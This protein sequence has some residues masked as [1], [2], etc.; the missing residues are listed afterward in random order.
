MARQ[1]SIDR[2]VRPARK[3]QAGYP[4]SGIVVID[5]DGSREYC[6]VRFKEEVLAAVGRVLPEGIS[7]YT[8]AFLRLV[9][10]PRNEWALQVSYIQEPSYLPL[11]YYDKIPNWVGKRVEL[12]NVLRDNATSP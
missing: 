12:C 10:S 1:V 9:K 3:P 5:E 6:Y 7:K 2:W 11:T 4:L 8:P